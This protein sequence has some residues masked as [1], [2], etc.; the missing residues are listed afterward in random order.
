M[1][2]DQTAKRYH[3][4]KNRLFFVSLLFNIALLLFL[5][6]SGLS[7]YLKNQILLF[8]QH[9]LAVNAIYAVAFC[10]FFTILGFPLNFYEG[11]VLE[12]RFNLSNQSFPDWLKDGAKNFVLG[13]IIILIG[14]EG[15]YLFLR[16]FPDTWWLWATLFWLFLTVVIARITPALIIPLFFKYRKLENPSLK[17]KIFALLDKAGVKIKDIFYI[18][19]SAKTKKANAFICGFANNRRLVLSD[20]LLEKFSEEEILAVVAHELGHY[21]NRDIGK[22][23]LANCAV[24]FLSFFL[25]SRVLQGA[26]LFF[27][28]S[29]I[30]DIAFLPFLALGILLLGFLMLPLTNAFSRRLERGADGFSLKLTQDPGNFISMMRKLGELNLADFS[31]HPLIEILLYDHPPIAKRIKF[32]EGFGK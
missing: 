18:D 4:I 14:V 28:F 5:G 19:F 32:A 21:K 9:F 31:P 15:L 20:T 22:L 25:I 2:N 16:K 30:D 8:N 17:A 1:I 23:I 11:F 24:S 29:R 3:Q 12:H 26:L 10:V 13:L 7:V 27:G 6:L